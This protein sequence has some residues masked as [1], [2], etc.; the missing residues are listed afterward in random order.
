MFNAVFIFYITVDCSGS[1][2]T[3]T[4]DSGFSESS[5]NYSG[6]RMALPS[7]GDI[8]NRGCEASAKPRPTP[9]PRRPPKSNTGYTALNVNEV[10]LPYY[11][12]MA[13][14]VNQQLQGKISWW[15][16]LVTIT[17]V[18]LTYFAG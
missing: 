3:G 11:K 10:K 12:T 6:R 18:A 13:R 16:R 2:Y 15:D 4:G 17:H 8:K 9:A 14:E 7:P 1:D 5:W